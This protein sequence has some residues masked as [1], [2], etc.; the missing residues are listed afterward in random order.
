MLHF[1]FV[2][3]NFHAAAATAC[4]GFDDHGIADFLTQLLGF[5]QCRHTTIRAWNAGNAEVFHRILGGDL[6]TH[7]ADMFGGGADEG[8]VMIFDDLDEIGVFAQKSVTGVNGL[9]AGHLTGGNYRGDRQVAFTAGGGADTDGF[10]RHPYMH[11]V[12][13]GGRMNGD[14]TDAHFAGGPDNAQRDLTAVGH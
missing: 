1:A 11:R 4:G 2:L 5:G 3:G 10:V 13:I 6:V 14:R 8:Q 12:A 7:N 9:C